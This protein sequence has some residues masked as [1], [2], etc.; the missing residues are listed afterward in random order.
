MKKI[1]FLLLVIISLASCADN[2]TFTKKDGTTFTAET[3]GWADS[4]DKKIDGVKYK[5]CVGNVVWSVLLFETVGVPVWLTG[6]ELYE[7]ISYN[8]P[9]VSPT[10]N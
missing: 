8:E 9:I 1:L 10:T 6:W 4:S 2:K 7:P 5:V 3:Y